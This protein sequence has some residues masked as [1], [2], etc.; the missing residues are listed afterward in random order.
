VVDWRSLRDAYGDAGD[1]PAFLR[2]LSPDPGNEVWGE[3]WSRLCHQG[4]VY[5]ASFASLPHLLE[6]AQTILP[7]QR[8]MVLALAG[9]IIVS[10]HVAS[11]AEERPSAVAATAPGLEKLGLETLAQTDLTQSDFLS[12][13]QAVLATRGERVWGTQLDHL[14]SGEFTGECTSCGAD[15]YLAVGEYG[16]FTTVDDW[17]N[18]SDTRQ[19]AIVPTTPESLVGVQRWLYDQAIATRHQRIA[20]WLLYAFGST[21]C[22]TCGAPMSVAS[23]VERGCGPTK[24]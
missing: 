17:V 5:S 14:D 18:R 3:L 8:P 7:G 6:W 13:A 2:Q 11:G 19:T 10:D 20:S 1:V 9:A 12:T 24:G 22:P 21:A 16:F 4:T 23:A 15:L